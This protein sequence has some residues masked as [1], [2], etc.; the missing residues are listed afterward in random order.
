MS[1]PVVEEMLERLR[2]LWA[3]AP[4]VTP[5]A[6]ASVLGGVKLTGD[7][8]GTA[9]SPTVPSLSSKRDVVSG[10]ARVYTND[11]SG[12]PSSISYSSSASASTMMFRDT[13]GRTKVNAPSAG[14]DAA[15]K[16]YVDT[17]LARKAD[18]DSNGKL[19]AS[20]LPDAV[21]IGIDDGLI[22]AGSTWSS[23]KI[24]SEVDGKVSAS[25]GRLADARDTTTARITDA[26]DTGRAMVKAT[27]KTAARAAIDAAEV[28]HTHSFAQ[29]PGLVDALDAKAP[30]LVEYIHPVLD[31]PAVTSVAAMAREGD[32]LTARAHRAVRGGDGPPPED[33]QV[34]GGDVWIDFTTGKHYTYEQED[35]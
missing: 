6:T 21:G 34:R 3:S 2:A 33:L 17:G 16:E 8:G 14:T 29:L 24:K 26:T 32:A 1:S 18:L 23:Q 13:S 9:E 12:S 19:L 27:D 28:S 22:S 4:G 15:N 7:L 5:P 25:D 35:A 11:G 31:I 30:A 20:Q 10:G